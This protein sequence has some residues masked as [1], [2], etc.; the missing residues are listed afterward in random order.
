M[1]NPSNKQ[2]YVT[3]HLKVSGCGKWRSR[4]DGQRLHMDLTLKQLIKASLA[5]AGL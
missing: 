2:E 1:T 5:A 4:Y 3:I